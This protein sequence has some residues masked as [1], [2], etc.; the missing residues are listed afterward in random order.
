MG[1]KILEKYL[2]TVSLDEIIDRNREEFMDLLSMLA[3]EHECLE[4]IS[5]RVAGIV[6]EKITISIMAHNPFA[7][8]LPK[9][10][11]ILQRDKQ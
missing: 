11:E 10:P 9:Y 8:G 4:N 1:Q 5:Y 7:N 2:V 3:V 6:D